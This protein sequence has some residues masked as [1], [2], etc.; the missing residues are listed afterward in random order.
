[1]VVFIAHY[2]VAPLGA[3]VLSHSIR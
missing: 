1:M 3:V 2:A